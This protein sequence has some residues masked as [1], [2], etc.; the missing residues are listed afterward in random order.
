MIFSEGHLGSCRLE[1][2]DDPFSGNAQHLDPGQPANMEALGAESKA[3]DDPV[4][5]Q[6]GLHPVSQGVRTGR[7]L[8]HDLSIGLQALHHRVDR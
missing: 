6:S 8:D 5:P 1:H 3:T 2:L 4:K 7:Y